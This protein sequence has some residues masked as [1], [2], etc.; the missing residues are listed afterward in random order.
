MFPASGLRGLHPRVLADLPAA[1]VWTNRVG[2]Q[3]FTPGHS[4]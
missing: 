4:A 2:N 3:S 1:K